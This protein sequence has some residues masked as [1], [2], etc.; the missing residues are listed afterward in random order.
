MIGLRLV[1]FTAWL[2]YLIGVSVS[3]LVK[4]LSVVSTIK[5]SAGG[6]NTGM[7]KPGIHPGAVV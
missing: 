6:V 2:H 1:V 5:I 3:N 7:E 4:M